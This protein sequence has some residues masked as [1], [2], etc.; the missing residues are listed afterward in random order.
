[1]HGGGEGEGELRGGEE[2]GGSVRGLQEVD[3]GDDFGEADVRRER[4]G[5]VAPLFLVSELEGAPWGHR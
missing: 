2:V 3:D 1:M 5:A 4:V